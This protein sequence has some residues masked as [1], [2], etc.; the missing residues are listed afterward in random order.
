M[1]ILQ[2]PDGLKHFTPVAD[3]GARSVMAELRRA[4]LA[5]RYAPMPVEEIL[6]PLG[7]ALTMQEATMSLAELK[8][9]LAVHQEDGP[10]QLLAALRQQTEPAHDIA[11]GMVVHALA[12]IEHGTPLTDILTNSRAYAPAIANQAAVA[13]GG[14]GAVADPG[15]KDALFQAMRSDAQSDAFKLSDVALLAVARLAETD[16]SC[17][18]VTLDAVQPWL[19]AAAS[20]E[21]TAMALHACA[22]ALLDDPAVVSRARQLSKSEDPTISRAAEEF[23]EQ[24]AASD[25]Q[26]KP[27]Q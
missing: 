16:P 8:N 18:Q 20:P 9:W 23:L 26:P 13:A 12:G 4:E 22:N 24:L 15:L 19:E 1:A 25:G 6:A 3:R 5:A 11:S 17:R 27:R 7:T 2:N 21:Q 14:L 10:G